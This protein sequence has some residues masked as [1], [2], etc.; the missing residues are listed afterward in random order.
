MHIT[1]LVHMSYA[2]VLIVGTA[3]RTPPPPEPA[4]RPLTAD[5][6]ESLR[7]SAPLTALSCAWM[8][9]MWL[10]RI[11]NSAAHSAIS[12]HRER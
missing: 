11:P 4:D 10:M 3:M 7:P 12:R 6:P 9:R 1:V 2:T 5:E 8:S